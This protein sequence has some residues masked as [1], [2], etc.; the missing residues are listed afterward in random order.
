MHLSPGSGEATGEGSGSG[1][2]WPQVSWQGTAR[3]S[4]QEE[5]FCE[6]VKP[7]QK[8]GSMSTQ[9]ALGHAYTGECGGEG[10]G[11]F[12]GGKGGGEGSSAGEGDG[13]GGGERIQATGH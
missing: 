10:G 3:R 4:W 6:A 8:L 1:E 13:G 11:G 2:Q 12:G 7:S 5:F 9:V